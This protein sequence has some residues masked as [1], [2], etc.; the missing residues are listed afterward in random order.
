MSFRGFLYFAGAFSLVIIFGL[1][2]GCS[3]GEFLARADVDHFPRSAQFC[4]FSKCD[5]SR[6][7]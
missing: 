7:N 6:V 2:A 4:G 5:G 1:L 3:S